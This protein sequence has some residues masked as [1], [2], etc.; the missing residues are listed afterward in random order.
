METRRKRQDYLALNDGYD[1]AAL[2]DERISSPIADAADP[3]L[4]S[5]RYSFSQTELDAEVDS[6][7]HLPESE[8]S[9]QNR[10][11]NNKIPAQL[12]PSCQLLRQA[13]KEHSF[14]NISPERSSERVV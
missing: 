5:L 4:S 8:V 3:G 9:L 1:T 12:L 11:H 13:K 2:K 6:L 14:A 7:R 10:H